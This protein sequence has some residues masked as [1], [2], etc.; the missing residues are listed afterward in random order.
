V[1]FPPGEKICAPEKRAQARAAFKAARDSTSVGPPSA[2]HGLGLG[3]GPRRCAGTIAERALLLRVTAASSARAPAAAALDQ[4]LPAAPPHPPPIPPAGPRPPA[5]P[6]TS[7][8]VEQRPGVGRTTAVTV[9][10]GRR[11]HK[12]GGLRAPPGP[13]LVTVGCHCGRRRGVAVGMGARRA[14]AR[15]TATAKPRAGG[16]RCAVGGGG[17][18]PRRVRHGCARRSRVART[19]PS[20]GE[21]PPHG[22]AFVQTRG[23]VGEARRHS[24]SPSD[25][26]ALRPARGLREHRSLRAW[27]KE[28]LG[29][30]CLGDESQTCTEL[31]D[32]PTHRACTLLIDQPV[33]RLAAAMVTPPGHCSR[34]SDPFS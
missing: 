16:G 30:P 31:P 21:A 6:P 34:L 9:T 15:A 18:D 11:P 7:R 32:P 22:S 17:A 13:P 23:A 19:R 28:R 10:V 2:R 8:P 29:R 20:G 33:A 24:S 4:C 26:T 25:A 5:R 27:G 3:G 12:R 1:I 14:A